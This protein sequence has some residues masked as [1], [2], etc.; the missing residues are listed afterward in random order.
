MTT[1]LERP[2]GKA[3]SARVS[4]DHL[5]PET[6]N[7][8]TGLL[9]AVKLAG[10]L[11]MSTSEIA[12]ALKRDVSGLRRTPSSA[13]LQPQL[14]TLEALARTITHQ[15]GTPELMRMWLRAANPELGDEVPMTFV[16][17]GHAADLHALTRLGSEG[18]FN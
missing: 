18:V 6:R 15:L 2:T 16:L 3:S 8:A 12:Q 11:G 9:D 4:S 5:I 7:P 13:S 14:T 17:E 10:H 1:L